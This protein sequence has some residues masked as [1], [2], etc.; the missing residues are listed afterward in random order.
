MSSSYIDKAELLEQTP[1]AEE[2]A[3]S[4]GN[5]NVRSDAMMGLLHSTAQRVMPKGSRV[6]LYGSRA[7]GC[8]TPESDWDLL[9]L[10]DKPSIETDDFANFAYPFVLSGWEHGQD[11]SPQMYTY[12]DWQR[13]HITP[14][15]HNVERDKV[16]IYES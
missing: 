4:Y 14:Y 2:P 10:L 7:R 8:A 13:M 12:E 3:L 9:L 6:L 1:H 11:V 5:T 15:Y 16:L